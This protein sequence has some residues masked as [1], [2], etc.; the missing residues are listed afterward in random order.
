MHPGCP[1]SQVY[2]C[3]QPVDFRKSISGCCTY[4]RVRSMY[5][6]ASDA[7]TVG[8]CATIGGRVDARW[9]IGIVESVWRKPPSS[10]VLSSV[11]IGESG[12]QQLRAS[13]S[14]QAIVSLLGQNLCVNQSSKRGLPLQWWRFYGAE[15]GQG[16][17]H[18]IK[19]GGRSRHEQLV[20]VQLVNFLARVE[21]D[22]EQPPVGVLEMREREVGL[23]L[24]WQFVDRDEFAGTA[25][26]TEGREEK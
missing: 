4:R 10:N 19:L 8:C 24:L 1:I 13:R 7:A 15:R 16:G 20:G 14:D 12:F 23:D 17:S 3:R 25:G 21:I 6:L 9:R 22:K 2:L 11:A 26:K 5:R 18:R